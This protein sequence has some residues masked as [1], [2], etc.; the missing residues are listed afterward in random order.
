MNDDRYPDIERLIELDFVRAT[1]AAALN[2]FH[3][4]GRGQKEKAD[5]AACD[6]MRGMFD[7]MDIR[8]EV[9]IGEGIK[10]NA[11]GIFKGEKLGKWGPTAP[12]YHIAVDPIDGTTNVSKGAGSSISVIAA[13]SPEPGAADA[14]KDIPSFYTMKMAYG[15]QVKSY[16]E[17]LG[18][19]CLHLKSPI[20]EILPV[21]ARALRKRV[22]DLV[23][24]VLDRPRHERL[25]EE[26]RSAGCGLRLISDGDVTAAMAPSMPEGH[27]DVYL[28]IGGAPEAV[29]AAAAIKCLGGEMQVQMWPRDAT[30]REALIEQ[31]YGAELDRVFYADDLAK[32]NNILFCATAIL[33]C[34]GMAGIRFTRSH[35]V[36]HSLLVRAKNR[37]I[38]WI[39]T[40]HDLRY[41][42]IR[43][44][45]LA[46]ERPLHEGS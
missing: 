10:D 41:K 25:I 6:A 11:P 43:L 40:Y 24:C 8:G 15:P 5:A 46:K 27:I 39:Q 33:E 36:T 21:V 32:G 18:V 44:R 23:V 34:A 28:G 3:W 4:V 20:D 16:V 17:R 37:T 42:T 13:A 2:V 22:R 12:R 45:S 14:L 19:D 7:L 29:L 30:E 1:E 38:R 9:V 26:I 35:A 31:G